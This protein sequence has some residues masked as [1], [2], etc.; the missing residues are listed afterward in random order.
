MLPATE[1]SGSTPEEVLDLDL[2]NAD[3]ER[4]AAGASRIAE[5]LVRTTDPDLVGSLDDFLGAIYALVFARRGDF[6]DRAGTSIEVKVVQNRANQLAQGRV[7]ISGKW[8]AG[9]HFNSALFRTSAVYH[10]M[11]KIIT[12]R[13][14]NV[15]FLR[16]EAEQHYRTT[17]GRD[18]PNTN[19]RHVH[20]QVNNLKHDASGTYHGR[21]ITYEQALQAVQELLDLIET[22]M[23]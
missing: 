12:G 20:G 3:Y 10:R 17:T 23:S 15:G 6:T 16:E 9:L 19:L 11:L 1:A 4:L 5:L 22:T 18:W 14:G 8:M 13:D 21:H 7:R 2:A